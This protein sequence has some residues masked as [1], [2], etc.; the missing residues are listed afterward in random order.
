MLTP[1]H[2]LQLVQKKRD[3]KKLKKVTEVDDLS[4]EGNE[5][6]DSC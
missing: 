1:S 2:P 3:V 5:K 6:Y 4:E